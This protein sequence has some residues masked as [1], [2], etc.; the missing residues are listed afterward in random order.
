MVLT[1]AGIRIEVKLLQL[2]NA[3]FPMLVIKLPR[4]TVFKFVLLEKEDSGTLP[5]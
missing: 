4:T 3:L 2:I 1:E 5:E